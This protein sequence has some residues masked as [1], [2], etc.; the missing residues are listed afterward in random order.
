MTLPIALRPMLRTGSLFA[1]SLLLPLAAYPGTTLTG[2][3]EFSTDPNGNAQNCLIW[4]T[5]PDNYADLWVALDSDATSPLNGPADSQSPLN[6]PLKTGSYRFYT[7]GAPG[8]CSTAYNG[9]NLFFDGNNSTPGISVFGPVNDQTFKANTANTYSLQIGGVTGAGRNFY[10]STNVIVVLDGYEWNTPATPPGDVCQS[11]AFIPDSSGAADYFGSFFLHVFPEGSV[12]IDHSSGSPGTR[13]TLSGTG[14]GPS[15]QV[16]IS[17]NSISANVLSTVTADASGSFTTVI[18]EPQRPYESVMNLFVLG[19]STGI[20]AITEITV[21]PGLTMVPE[22]LA[23]GA[24]TAV[25]GAGFGA[26]ENVSVYLDQPRVL[27]GT[28]VSD[29]QGSFIGASALKVTIPDDTP[30]GLNGLIGIG[31]TTSAVGI[32]KIRIQ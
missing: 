16:T 32:G 5:L 13:V 2:A 15:E 3:V 25:H 24:V 1:A 23:A 6:I 29:G 4:N 21:T 8:G 17:V 14:F 20:L 18:H 26:S 11:G 7:F 12:G 28:I 9:L 10:R 22:M 31:Q 30:S 19:Q 27:L